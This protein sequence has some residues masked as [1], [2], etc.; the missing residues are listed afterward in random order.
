MD[1][2][3]FFNSLSIIVVLKSVEYNIWT[4]SQFL[5]TVFYPLEDIFLF[6]CMSKFFIQNGKKA[7]LMQYVLV[8]YSIVFFRDVVLSAY[9]FFFIILVESWLAYTHNAN[10]FLLYEAVHI[11]ILLLWLLTA[12]TLGI[13]PTPISFGG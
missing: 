8:I 12:G 9:C 5:L 3:F 1:T 2:N 13:S 10:V 11:S 7:Y 4:Q 6:L